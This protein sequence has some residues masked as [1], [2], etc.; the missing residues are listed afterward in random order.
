M[1]VEKKRRKKDENNAK[2]YVQ[3]NVVNH[4]A[5]GSRVDCFG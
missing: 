3:G 4:G 5:H 1:E 2:M